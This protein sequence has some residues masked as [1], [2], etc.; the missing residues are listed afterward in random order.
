M[1]TIR[2]KRAL[3]VLTVAAAMTATFAL[4]VHAAGPYIG[5]RLPT[6]GATR[7]VNREAATDCNMCYTCGGDWPVFAGTWHTGGGT[8]SAYERG[9][10]CSGGRTWR[11]DT[12]PYLCCK[13]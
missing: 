12:Y 10:S 8:Y 4:P 9:S 7:A 5:K 6:Q 1:T 13:D 11:T 3:L 2:N